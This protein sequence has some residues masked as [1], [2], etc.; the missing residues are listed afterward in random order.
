MRVSTFVG[1]FF[2]AL[3]S[4]AAFFLLSGYHAGDTVAWMALGLAAAVFAIL[5][6]RVRSRPKR[7]W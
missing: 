1:I 6:S 5:T 4:G 3:V 2:A 7:S